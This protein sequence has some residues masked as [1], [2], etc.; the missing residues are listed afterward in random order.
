MSQLDLVLSFASHCIYDGLIGMDA[1]V[2]GL[3]SREYGRGGYL[4]RMGRGGV[5]RAM[6]GAMPHLRF[7]VADI[8]RATWGQTAAVGTINCS[9]YDCTSDE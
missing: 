8:T 9:W 3:L 5:P 4:Q 6:P 7:A 1:F 2:E